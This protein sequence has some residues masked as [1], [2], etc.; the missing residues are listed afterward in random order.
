MTLGPHDKP[1]FQKDLR[2]NHIPL[3]TIVSAVTGLMVAISAGGCAGKPES[4]GKPHHTSEGFQN[5]DTNEKHGFMDFV[6]WR[7]ER[8]KKD[9]PG[10]ESYNFPM[11]ENDPQWL[12]SDHGRITAT[13]IGHAALLLQV[14]GKNILTDP[15]F[16]E[17][18]SPVQ[19]A[20]PRRVASPGIALDNL[21]DID[22][23]LISHDHY[24]ALDAGSIELLTKRRNGDKTR[25]FVPMG[26]KR[27]FN[28]A[29]IDN[30]VELDWWESATYSDVTVH[31]VPVQHWSKRTPFSRNTTLWAGWAVVIDDFRFFF[32]GDS[33]YCDHFQE[34]G[35]RLGPFDLAALPIG[36][37]EPRWFMGRHHMNPLEAAQVHLDI[38]AKHSVAIHW[39][40][41]IL[42]DEPLDEPPV[43]LAEALRQKAIPPEA[44]R[45]LK[46]GETWV[47]DR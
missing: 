23:V 25:F 16:S 45:V 15:V 11:A 47:L 46:H 8:R 44:F 14:S 13:W 39:G 33:G 21:P 1:F 18:A 3:L 22:M 26:L 35:K 37:Y 24:D 12:A 27:W 5:S 9:I 43:R 30:V 28:R 29:G 40:T 32:A 7:M 31:A 10:P 36:A 6:K 38:R 42:T 34:I 41:F 20:G 2:M 4:A 19:W 17:R